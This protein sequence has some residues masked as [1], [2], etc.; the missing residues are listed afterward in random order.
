MNCGW[1][2][3]TTLIAKT[4]PALNGL[5]IQQDH[6]PQIRRPPDLHSD[7]AGTQRI[8]SPTTIQYP[9]HF[10]EN[11]NLEDPES[12]ERNFMKFPTLS[13]S[14]FLPCK[15]CQKAQTGGVE[16]CV[17][18][19]AP[20]LQKWPMIGHLFGLRLMLQWE[21]Q[22]VWIKTRESQKDWNSKKRKIV[23]NF[24][25]QKNPTHFKFLF[26]CPPFA[27]P[28]MLRIKRRNKKKWFQPSKVS[29]GNTFHRF[30][31]HLFKGRS[32]EPVPPEETPEWTISCAGV[33]SPSAS[34]ISY[35][36]FVW[37]PK[38]SGIRSQ[39]RNLRMRESWS[40]GDHWHIFFNTFA[41]CK[42]L[43]LKALSIEMSISWL[44]VSDKSD[45]V[46]H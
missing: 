4:W 33:K 8:M 34:A 30:F 23:G 25:S 1:I 18:K 39:K 37:G 5:L 10:L 26:N 27:V 14:L 46:R 32:L 7:Q 41:N 6:V 22:N 16:M 15:F 21:G 29:K 3:F 43:N 9:Q 42:G 11:L 44:D 13:H 19:D 45:A 24:H 20:G 28:W 17:A 40:H 31:Q 38:K 2:L 36:R 35:R 12:R